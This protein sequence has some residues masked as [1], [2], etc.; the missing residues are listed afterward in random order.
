MSTNPAPQ[1]GPALDTVKYTKSYPPATQ[2]AIVAAVAQGMTRFSQ[3]TTHADS[4]VRLDK[5]AGRI[6][7]M[8]F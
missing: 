8:A 4:R 7:S 6:L 2:A 5:T 1:D 3:E